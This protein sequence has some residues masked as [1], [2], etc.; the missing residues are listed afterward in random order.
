MAIRTA[1]RPILPLALVCLGQV[2]PA[3]AAAAAASQQLRGRGL[4]FQE[5]HLRFSGARFPGGGWVSDSLSSPP[6]PQASE[7]LRTKAVLPTSEPEP[8]E[9]NAW[10]AVKEAQ[11]ENTVTISL[12]SPPDAVIGRYLL[13]FRVSSHR[14]HSD[15]KLGEFVLLFNPWCSGRSCQVQ[16]RGFPEVVL[17][18][19]VPLEGAWEAG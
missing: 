18:E 7:A 17:E 11:E 10:T 14:K 8:E 4:H 2:L 9:K 6:G 3:A 1:E 16:G 13:S 15:R 12:T 5:Q 19:G